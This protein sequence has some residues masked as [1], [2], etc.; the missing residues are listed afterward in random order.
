MKEICIRG[1]SRAA[2]V[3]RRGWASP[4]TAATGVRAAQAS[5]SSSTASGTA[6]YGQSSSASCLHYFLSFCSPLHP[7][8]FCAP[9]TSAFTCVTA[10]NAISRSSRAAS[11]RHPARRRATS[12]WQRGRPMPQAAR[13][14]AARAGALVAQQPL[15]P[16]AEH[17]FN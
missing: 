8:A 11:G 9:Q 17:R 2:A 13:S 5:P 10:V 1:S 12:P 7:K 4:A 16:A 14:P 6:S 15:L 3:G